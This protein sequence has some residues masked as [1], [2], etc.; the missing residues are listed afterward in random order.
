MLLGRAPMGLLPPPVTRGQTSTA[1][2]AA[3]RWA[4]TS[5]AEEARPEAMDELMRMRGLNHVKSV[6]LSLHTQVRVDA[7]PAAT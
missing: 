4:K 6:A 2:S 7:A 3:A 1:D 5:T